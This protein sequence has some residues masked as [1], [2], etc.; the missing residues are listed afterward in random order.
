MSP[1]AVFRTR[2]RVPWGS[3][4]EM[5]GVRPS[6]AGN[7]RELQRR[8]EARHRYSLLVGDPLPSSSVN[9][10]PEEAASA[11]KPSLALRFLSGTQRTALTVARGGGAGGARTRG[12]GG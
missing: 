12:V 11:S 9:R 6:R 4:K 5:P 2:S 3:R 7:G 10:P 1:N 8:S